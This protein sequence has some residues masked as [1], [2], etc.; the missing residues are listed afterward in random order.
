[1][2]PAIA[3]VDVVGAY[4]G[5]TYKLHCCAVEQSLVTAGAGAGEQHLR[6]A[7]HFAV[8]FAGRDICYLLSDR[9]KKTFEIG[10]LDIGN[11]FHQ[12]MTIA[13]IKAMSIATR[14]QVVTGCRVSCG[15]MTYQCPYWMAKHMLS[16]GM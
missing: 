9:L 2:R 14:S 6:I 12:A 3:K 8:D 5:S 4:G 1:M 16:S 15:V 13:M 7:Q 11:D 10:N